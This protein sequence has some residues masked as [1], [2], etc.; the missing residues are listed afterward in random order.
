MKQDQGNRESW[1]RIELALAISEREALTHKLECEQR[2]EESLRI[3]GRAFQREG[4]T[5]AKALRQDCALNVPAARQ[6]LFIV[7]GARKGDFQW[8]V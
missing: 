6:R 2:S 4:K 7:V 5:N 8:C 3:W 1:A